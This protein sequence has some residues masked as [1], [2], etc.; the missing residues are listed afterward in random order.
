EK[1]CNVA[2][3]APDNAPFRRE[4]RA[5]AAFSIARGLWRN[6]A[7]SRL[8]VA[9]QLLEFDVLEYHLHGRPGMQLPGDDAFLGHLGKILVHG[10]HAVDLDRYVLADDLDLVIVETVFLEDF[11]DLVLVGGFHH[12]A[13]ILAVQAAPPALAHVT[14]GPGDG[15]AF[16]VVDLAAD[17]HAAVARPAL[18]RELHQETQ[19]EILVLFL[20]AQ[21]GVE[22]AAVGEG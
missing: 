22:F 16:H 5:S 8:L 14:L 6:A 13:E 20:A 9:S 18:A 19:L 12:A 10:C 2:L 11:V 1:S 3:A 15:K 7:I 17:L 4:S 21:E